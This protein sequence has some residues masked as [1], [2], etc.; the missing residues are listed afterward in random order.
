MR[1]NSIRQLSRY[2]KK[3]L[4]YH[5]PRGRDE[6][7]VENICYC[8]C[9][10][11]VLVCVLASIAVSKGNRYAIVIDLITNLITGLITHL[12]ILGDH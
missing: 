3:E 8:R 7:G 1:T 4:K 9:S 10:D 2:L 6:K 11:A 5:T 12:I